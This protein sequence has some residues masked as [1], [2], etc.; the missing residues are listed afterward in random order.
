MRGI[1]STLEGFDCNQVMYEY[2]FEKAWERDSTDVGDWIEAYADRRH[3]SK[4]QNVR[5]AWRTLAE[6]IYTWQNHLENIYW[7]NNSVLKREAYE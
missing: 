2:V 6:K 1:G 3:G 7:V 5:L 4:D